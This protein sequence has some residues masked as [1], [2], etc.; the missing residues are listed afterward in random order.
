MYSNPIY[1]LICTFVLIGC[2]KWPY[3][4]TATPMAIHITPLYKSYKPI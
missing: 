4:N 3:R 2:A 1:K